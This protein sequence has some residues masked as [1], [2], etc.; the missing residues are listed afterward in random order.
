MPQNSLDLP[1]S[2]SIGVEVDPDIFR[3]TCERVR[4][5]A[6]TLGIPESEAA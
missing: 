6:E 5:A 1:L 4:A 3:S 2:P